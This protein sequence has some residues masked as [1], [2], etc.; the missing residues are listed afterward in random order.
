MNTLTRV[1]MIGFSLLAPVAAQQ[2]LAIA[3]FQVDATPPLG[4]PL[5]GGAVEPAKEIV[6]PLSARGIVLLN[7]GK[8]IVLVAVDWV[9]IAN[10]ALDEWRKT[11]AEAVGTTVDRVSVHTV[12]QHDAPGYDLSAERLLEARGLGGAHFSPALARRT[13]EQAAQALRAAVRKPQPVTHLGLGSGLVQQVASNRRVL[14]PDGKVKYVRYSA[15]RIPEARA[16]PEGTVDPYVRL[17][18]F[19][20]GDRPLASLTYYATH[21]QSYYGKGGVSADFVGM[22]RTLQERELPGVAHIHFNGAAGNVTAGK[23]NDGAPELRP[24]LAG[25]LAAGMQA[26]WRAVKKVPLRA[27]DIDWRVVPVA[28]P[29]SPRLKDEGPIRKILDDPKTPLRSRIGAA[30]DLAWIERA[31]GRQIELAC[32]RLGPAR[33]IHMPGELFVEYQLAAQKMRPGEFVAMAAYG[34]YGPGYIGTRI[35]YSEGGYETGPAS[36]TSPEVESVLM[37]A[38]ETLLAQPS[39]LIVNTPLPPPKWALLERELLQANSAACERFAARYLDERGYLLHTPRWGTLD[40]PDDAI[41]TFYNWTLLH[42]LGASDSVLRLFKKAHEGHLQQ[43]QQLRT[44]KTELARDGAYYKEFVTMS[45]W[46][47]TGE[48]MRGFMFLGLSDPADERFRQRMRRFAGLYMNEDPEAPNYDPKHRIIRSLWTG[49][50]GPMLRKATT[51]DWVGDPVP[52]RFHLLHSKGGRR[53]LLDLEANYEKMLAHCA[54]YLD[55]VG[56]HPLNLAATNL[57]L[58]A[59]MLT[60]EKKYRDW[61]LEYVNAWKQRTEANGGNIPTNIGL[62]GTIGGEYGGKWYKGTYGWNFTIFDGEIE[63]IAHRNTFDAGMWP[64]FGNA[65]LLTGDPAYIAT[66][67]RQM[68]NLYAQ[69]KVIDGKLMLPQMYGDPR[70]HKYSGQEAWYHWTANLHTNRLT[71]IYLWSCDRKDLDRIPKTDW[72][73]FLEGQSPGYPEEALRAE[74]SAVRAKVEEMDRDNTTPD[75]RL[76]DYLM[77]FNPAR[78]DALA[79]LTLGGYLTGNIWTLHSR[80]R[81]FDPVRRRSG[82]P[83]DVAALVEKLSADSVTL[84]LVNTNQAAARTLIV[85]AGGYGE[86]QFISAAWNGKTVPLDDSLVTV[87]LAPGCGARLELRMKRYA[88]QPAL[89]Q[90]WN[91]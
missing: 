53:Q 66:L 13:I 22:A 45:D 88:N 3:T 51:Y 19:W 68:D 82:L 43:Y 44:T 61:V 72:I 67:R 56:D 37:A 41:E 79:R 15:S 31:A 30:R 77:G 4:T 27:S 48:G 34:D 57:A 12:H 29:L 74:L 20:N 7:A 52:G 6:D 10:E 81:Y 35:A 9:G 11:L 50:K 32:L 91:R 42:A 62:D 24:V 86:H 76:A 65:Y 55:S 38:L 75:T 85:Q 23:Y 16:A 71:E 63:Q 1:W 33:V 25:R 49:S 2:R 80:V 73:A 8:P 54:E 83:E 36:R 17:I 87:R 28:L 21:P 39:A 70:G 40:G 59:Y 78:T 47:H 84:S 69:R 60:R 26:A 90:P 64:G 5:C 58:N 18:S 46:F 14:G 89:A